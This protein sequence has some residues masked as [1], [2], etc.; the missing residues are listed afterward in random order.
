MQNIALTYAH[1]VDVC[2][3]VWYIIMVQT[4]NP[5]QRHTLILEREAIEAVWTVVV[6]VHPVNLQVLV[7]F[8][9][10]GDKRPGWLL[11][12]AVMQGLRLADDRLRAM[13][14]PPCVVCVMLRMCGGFIVTMR[15][16]VCW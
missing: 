2:V 6:Q 3:H 16:V 14:H 15:T 9:L 5:N 4:T 8:Q 11:G 10:E 13:H 1:N 7:P 12:G